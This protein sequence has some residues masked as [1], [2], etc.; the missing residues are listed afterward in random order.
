MPTKP[1]LAHLQDWREPGVSN[2][3]LKGLMGEESDMSEIRSQSDSHC[4]LRTVRR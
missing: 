2:Q 3:D 1:I 4:V